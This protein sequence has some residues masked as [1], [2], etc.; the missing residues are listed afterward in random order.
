MELLTSPRQT[1]I[2]TIA[3]VKSIQSSMFTDN[4]LIRIN[5]KTKPAGLKDLMAILFTQSR[6]LQKSP[7]PKS[8]DTDIGRPE[9]F[10][11]NHSRRVRT[12]VPLLNVRLSGLH[13]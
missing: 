8:F 4:N 1:G 5:T 10:Q 2:L 3:G 7:G 6:P 12:F 9:L 11:G 13:N